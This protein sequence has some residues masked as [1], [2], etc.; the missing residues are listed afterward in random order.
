MNWLAVRRMSGAGNWYL[1][2]ISDGNC[3]LFQC[4]RGKK[5]MQ[6]EGRILSFCF[7]KMW[8]LKLTAE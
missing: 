1:M 7:E 4:R 5:M 2:S 8:I 3:L 6:N